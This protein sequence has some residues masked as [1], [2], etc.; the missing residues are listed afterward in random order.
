MSIANGPIADNSPSTIA[1]R[2]KL[3]LAV[4]GV[5]DRPLCDGANAQ[6]GG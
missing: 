4:C 5:I 6:I 1:L 3:V 2:A